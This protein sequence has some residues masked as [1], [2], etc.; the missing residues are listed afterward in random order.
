MPLQNLR[1]SWTFTQ[2]SMAYEI[3]SQLATYQSNTQSGIN[4][5]PLNTWME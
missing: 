2:Q 3:D 4:K 1:L 5:G